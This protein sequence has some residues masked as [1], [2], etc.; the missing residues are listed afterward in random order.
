MSSI[1]TTNDYSMFKHIK[2]NR[3]V[4]RAHVNKLRSVFEAKPEVSEWVPIIVN[5]KFQVIDGQHRL[6]AIEELKF[7]VHYRVIPGLTLDDVKALNSNTR[8]W[9]P[10]DYAEAYAISGNQNYVD[11]LEFKANFKLNH[12]TVMS[13]V[14]LGNPYT[15]ESFRNGRFKSAGKQ[16]SWKYGKYLMDLGQYVPH[17]KFRATAVAFLRMAMNPKYDH[18]RMMENAKILGAQ[19]ERFTQMEEA[20]GALS[21]IY[22]RHLPVAQKVEF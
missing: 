11:Y 8:P 14:A 21:K 10:N 18:K 2:G 20:V 19:L 1:Q 15:G 12:D 17:Y 4:K 3:K 5:E 9:G 22:N 6:E 7:P 13:Y 16:A